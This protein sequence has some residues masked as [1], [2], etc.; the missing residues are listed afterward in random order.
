MKCKKDLERHAYFP[1]IDLHFVQKYTAS[2][3]LNTECFRRKRS[4]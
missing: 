4:N 3:I 1:I 2:T